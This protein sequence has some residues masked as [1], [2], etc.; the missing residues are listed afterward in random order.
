MESSAQRHSTADH[1]SPLEVVAFFLPQFHPI[2]ENDRWWGAGFTEW[3]HAAAARPLFDGHIQ[4]RLPADLG[5]YDLRVPETRRAQWEMASQYGVT[6]LCYWHYW[7]GDGAQLLARPA[8]DLLENPKLPHRYCLGWANQSW[9]GVWHGRGDEI[10]QQQRYPGQA[11]HVRHFQYLLPHFLDER[12]LKVEA[13][14]VLYLFRPG[15]IPDLPGLAALWLQMAADAGL[16]GLY[17]VGDAD[18]SW[19]RQ[20]D[21][22]LDAAVWNPAPPP[23]G[24]ELEQSFAGVPLRE[25]PRAYLYDEIYAAWLLSGLPADVRQHPCVVPGFD[26]TP[27]SGSRGVLLHRPDP[28]VFEAAVETA[29]RRERAMPGPRMVFVKSWNEWAE[30]SIMEPDQLFGRSFLRALERG[31]R[32]QQ[33]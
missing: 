11:D 29:V 21:H 8:M 25:G 30:G 9:T 2:P 6:A 27:R 14:P 33:R 20:A 4:P 13:K 5:F 31:L 7:F 16:P 26:N 17:L 3:T 12:Y 32:L 24:H 23:R 15:A 10:L 22:P 28:D 1:G 19:M 18:G